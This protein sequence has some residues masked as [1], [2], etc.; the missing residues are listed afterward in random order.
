MTVKSNDCLS[1]YRHVEEYSGKKRDQKLKKGGI[2]AQDRCFREVLLVAREYKDFLMFE[3]NTRM[4]STAS[5]L[6][7]IALDGLKPT[8]TPVK[9]H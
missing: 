8:W 2:M 1:F 4:V 5:N 9:V 7:M 3:T 6:S